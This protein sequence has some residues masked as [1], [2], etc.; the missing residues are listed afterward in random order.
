MPCV[1]GVR[2]SDGHWLESL[3]GDRTGDVDTAASACGSLPNRYLVAISQAD[4]ALTLMWF[5][6]SAITP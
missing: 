6:S 5:A 1:P 2:D 3:P 4:A